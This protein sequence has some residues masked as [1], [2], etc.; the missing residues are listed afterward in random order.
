[1]SVA[2]IVGRF[3]PLH[4]GHTR[5][6][7][8]AIE[9]CETVIV[10]VGST[11]I[12]NEHNPWSFEE[13]KTML[14]NVYGKRISIVP[15]VDLNS[16]EG[17]SAWC[18]YVLG[19]IKKIGLPEPTILYG[20]NLSETEWYRDYFVEAGAKQQLDNSGLYPE[21]KKSQYT[22]EGELRLRT[23]VDRTSNKHLS[24]TQIRMSLRMN[25]MEWQNEVP[26]VN[27]QIVKNIPEE[28]KIKE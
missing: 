11:Q 26:K 5:I 21:W 1:M 17:S 18:E 15:L 2:L 28:F 16:Q 20:G 3:Q 25:S 23:I 9:D 6:I 8:Q 19:K 12:Q 13:R 24:G 14:Q 27:H 10:C 22:K 4:K 7:S